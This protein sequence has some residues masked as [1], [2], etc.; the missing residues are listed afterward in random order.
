MNNIFTNKHIFYLDSL[1]IILKFDSLIF[2]KVH[3]G[4]K[5]VLVGIL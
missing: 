4:N 5:K 2:N 1:V 3:S